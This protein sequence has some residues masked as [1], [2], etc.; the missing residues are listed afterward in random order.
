MKRNQHLSLGVT[1]QDQPVWFL[2]GVLF[3][4]ASCV[5]AKKENHG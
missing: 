5:S 3:F 2:S 1:L 4:D